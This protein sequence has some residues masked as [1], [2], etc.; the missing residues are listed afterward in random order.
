MIGATAH[1][2]TSNLDEGPI[3]SQDAEAITHKDMSTDLI[4]KGRDVERRVLARAV[5]LFTQDRVI[6]NGAKTVVF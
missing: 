1:F 3:T 5:T 4:R 6:L 2:V